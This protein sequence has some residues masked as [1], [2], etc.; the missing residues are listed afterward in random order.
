MGMAEKLVSVVCPWCSVGCRFYI[1]SV[2]GYPKKIEFDYENDIRNHGKLCPKGVAA[3]Q[4]LRHPDRL[5]RPLKRVGER[6]EGKFVEISWEEAI[7]EIA[8]KLSEIREKYG[9]E[10]L[11]FLGSER[12]S[13]EENYVLQKLARALGTNNLEYVCRLCQSTAV[14][15]KGKVLGHPGLTNPFEDI[16]KAKVI[17]IWGYNP[18]ASNPVFFG[19]YV[20]KAIIDNNATLI[21]VDPRKTETAKYADIHLQPYPGTDLAVALAMLNVIITKELYDKDFV[22]ERAEGLEK[23]ATI[24]ERYTPEWAEEV[25]GVPAELIRKAAITFATAGTAALLTN[26]GVNQHT[27]GTKTVMALTEMMV[28]CGYFGK[29]GVMS[30][31]IPGAHNG[32]GAGLAGVEPDALPGKF[33]LHAEQHRKRIEE[34]WGFKIPEKPGIT[35]VEMVDAI[36]EGKIRALYV[37]GTN[38]AKSLPNLKKVEKALKNIEFLV[39]QDIFLTETAKY[40]DIVLPA[41]AWFEKDATAISFERR[42]QRSFKA[43]EAPGEAKPD[44]EIIVM[45]AKELGLGKYFNYSSADDILREINRI[46]PPLAGA[47][48]ERL[49]KNLKGCM[50]PC[51]DENTET[52]RLFVKGFLTP[53]GKAQLIPVEYEDPGEVPDEEYPFWL[54]NYR[55]VGHFHTGTM[56]HRSKSLKK[57]WPEEYVEINE[58]DA[59]RLGIKDGD[60]VKVE[61]RRATLVLKAKVTPH[62]REGVVAIPWHWN[63]NY[64]TTD[65]LDEYAK[66]PELKTAAC[67]IS[68]VE[69]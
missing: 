55:F 56:S 42:I 14:V 1:V 21:V 32:M 39:V 25:S 27:N 59:K 8:K 69:G 30:G 50:I 41:A 54:T 24:V 17:V 45:L 52:P 64:L 16:L 47:T 49:K 19:Q 23:L 65:V 31:A 66:M 46:V 18:A 28:L 53:N 58:N 33:P 13:L 51:P 22:A 60:L 43:A 68:K 62:I 57:R 48:P 36:L 26:E 44:W 29:E 12:C 2:N 3:F 61:T 11:A 34:A 40:A 37:M 4:Y 38:P 63:V 6:G 20:E 15:G 5:K 67:R 10:A 7:K 9:P 35:Y